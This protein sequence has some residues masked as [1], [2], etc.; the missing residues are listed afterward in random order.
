MIFRILPLTAFLAIAL[1]AVLLGLPSTASASCSEGYDVLGTLCPTTATA[2]DCR[3]GT[4]EARGQL[5]IIT[6]NTSLF[7]LIGNR[8]GGD[9]RTTFAL[10]DMRAYLKRGSDIKYCI[11]VTGNYPLRP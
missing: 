3:L 11:T 10:P 5:L 6:S 8:Y 7:S 4:M 2:S 9:G 1:L